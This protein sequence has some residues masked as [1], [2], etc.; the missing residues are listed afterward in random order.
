M[1]LLTIKLELTKAVIQ[2]NPANKFP[3]DKNIPMPIETFDV[4]KMLY[5]YLERQESYALTK[6]VNNPK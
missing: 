6:S 5:T 4:T 1:L 3:L 2:T